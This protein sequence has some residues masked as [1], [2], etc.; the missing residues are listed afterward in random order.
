MS[1]QGI[2]W[3]HCF[4]CGTCPYFTTGIPQKCV[5]FHFEVFINFG[6]VFALFLDVFI[7][8]FKYSVFIA[9]VVKCYL[10]AYLCG[11]PNRCCVYKS[12]CKTFVPI[13]KTY[14]LLLKEYSGQYSVLIQIHILT[15]SEKLCK[16]Y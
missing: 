9:N 3:K 7:I 13:M 15:Q 16:I 2:Y 6:Q 14:S 4:G 5:L 12:C 8:D 1:L 11:A 10:M